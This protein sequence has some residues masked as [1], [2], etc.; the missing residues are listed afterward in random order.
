MTGATLGEV[1]KEAEQA[2]PSSGA[3]DA[4]A[5]PAPSQEEANSSD[6]G[7]VPGGLFSAPGGTG[8]FARAVRKLLAVEQR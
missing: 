4:E 2:A 3:D 7:S 6:K 5:Q 1:I 8:F